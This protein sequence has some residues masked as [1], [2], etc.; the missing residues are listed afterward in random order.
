MPGR[1]G[2]DQPQ[3]LPQGEERANR[4]KERRKRRRREND[5]KASSA[6]VDKAHRW[7]RDA[8]DA[9]MAQGV[10]RSVDST[11]TR[12]DRAGDNVDATVDES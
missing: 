8:S 3:R 11:R 1:K 2:A 6:K 9:D 7:H 5:E 12:R 10:N 4:E